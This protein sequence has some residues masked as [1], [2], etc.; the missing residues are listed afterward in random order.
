[1]LA[2]GTV[3]VVN[4]GRDGKILPATL[5]M[6]EFLDKFLDELN[7][8]SQWRR[9][10]VVNHCDIINQKEIHA[11]VDILLRNMKSE[12]GNI[13][14]SMHVGRNWLQSVSIN[15]HG[16]ASVGLCTSSCDESYGNDCDLQNGGACGCDS[17]SS[18]HHNLWW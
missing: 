8:T 18:H 13:N 12:L 7:I 9:L 11:A 16:V 17:G 2:D 6:T 3:H 10:M 15:D 14:Q 1:V 5:R 4:E